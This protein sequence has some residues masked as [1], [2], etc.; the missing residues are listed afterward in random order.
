M[1]A[2]ASSKSQPK[3]RTRAAVAKEAKLPERKLRAVAAIKK[4][5]PELIP[6]V[7]ARE[8]TIAQATREIRE[9][10]AKPHE[11]DPKRKLFDYAKRLFRDVDPATRGKALHS[12]FKRLLDYFQ[13]Q[14][15]EVA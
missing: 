8:L 15:S 11:L 12:V 1:E 10:D 5:K 3:E 9:M 14:V 6:K 13:V 2:K 4:K 7:L